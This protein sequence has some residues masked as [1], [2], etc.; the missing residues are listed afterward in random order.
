M[1]V[2]GLS[3]RGD[4]SRYRTGGL[5]VGPGRLDVFVEG[6]SGALYHQSYAGA[7]GRAGK[8]SAGT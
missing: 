2:V 5:L 3:R 6:M 7:R 8:T 1:A 4:L